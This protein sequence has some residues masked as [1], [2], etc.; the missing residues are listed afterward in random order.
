VWWLSLLRSSRAPKR[1]RLSGEIAKKRRK[2]QLRVF[3][4]KRLML[5]RLHHHLLLPNLKRRKSRS[6]N[7]RE[8]LAQE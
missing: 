4:C 6:F 7:L 1:L 2:I 3:N 8:W 5:V